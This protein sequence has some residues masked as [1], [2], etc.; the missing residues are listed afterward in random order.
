MFA[1]ADVVST[2]SL[3]DFS[4][5]TPMVC[6][7]GLRQD[8]SRIV[9]VKPGV[10]PHIPHMH[11]TRVFH[12]GADRKTELASMR[13][14]E[15]IAPEIAVP[16]T[17]DRKRNSNPEYNGVYMRWVRGRPVQYRVT[18]T[19][20]HHFDFGCIAV[21]DA[22]L[23]NTDRHEGNAMVT[24]A[25]VYPIDHG[26]CLNYGMLC[27]S[28]NSIARSNIHT[29]N[30]ICATLERVHQYAADITV[31]ANAV[32]YIGSADDIREWATTMK[33]AAYEDYNRK[34][35]KRW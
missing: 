15:L 9:T 2:I 11:P 27:K 32:K 24:K 7:G 1:K 17:P 26:L 8:F 31:I 23:G 19:P 5:K 34:A 29:F 25:H 14:I 12:K 4:N 20:Q 28:L 18:Y 35:P 3:E 13:V 10:L 21:I 16:M 22:L 6:G 30:G 33:K